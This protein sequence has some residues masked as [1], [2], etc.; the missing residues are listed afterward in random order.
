MANIIFCAKGAFVYEISCTGYSHVRSALDTNLIGVHH[1]VLG[2]RQRNCKKPDVIN[3]ATAG[4]GTLD[5]NVI[6]G[7]KDLAQKLFITTAISETEHK[8]VIANV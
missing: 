6:L 5:Y 2:L 7:A 4:Q 8:E 1:E 3:E